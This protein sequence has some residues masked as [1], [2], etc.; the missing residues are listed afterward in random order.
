MAATAE[1]TG[2]PVRIGR[3]R[4]ISTDRR[5]TLFWSYVFLVLFAVTVIY[6]DI[7]KQLPGT[8]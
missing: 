1:A 5:R 8:Q 4:S 7:I 2:A 6:N 3:R